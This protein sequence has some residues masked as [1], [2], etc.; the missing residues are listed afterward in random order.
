MSEPSEEIVKRK[1]GERGSGTNLKS[2]F[3][4]MHAA[5]YDYTTKQVSGTG[6]RLGDRKDRYRQLKGVTGT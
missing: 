4:M 1:E 6:E 2:A 3:I 5:V